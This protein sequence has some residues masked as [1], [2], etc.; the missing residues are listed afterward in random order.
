VNVATIN[1]TGLANTAGTG[2]TTITAAMNGVS[3][4]AVLTVH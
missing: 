2:T 4:T 1:A 3:G